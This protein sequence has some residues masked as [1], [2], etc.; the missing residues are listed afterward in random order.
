VSEEELMDI[1]KLRAVRNHLEFLMPTFQWRVLTQKQV[2]H[3]EIL[4]PPCAILRGVAGPF[5]ID[6]LVDGEVIVA[7]EPSPAAAFVDQ[8]ALFDALNMAKR[9]KDIAILLR[10]N[11]RSWNNVG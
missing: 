1:G 3:L 7:W 4:D 5:R 6:L 8:D 11:L 9:P 2:A 10:L